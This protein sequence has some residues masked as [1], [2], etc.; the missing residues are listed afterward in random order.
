M[1]DVQP[2]GATIEQTLSVVS[3]ILTNADVA[4]DVISH[5]G[6]VDGLSQEQTALLFLAS[7]FQW[8]V[9]L[10]SLQNST[11]ESQVDGLLLRVKDLEERVFV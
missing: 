2:T 1:T 8:A 11:L 6:W 4:K 7:R 10:L 5:N 3:H 9:E